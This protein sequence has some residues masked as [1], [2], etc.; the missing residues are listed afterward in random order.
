MPRHAPRWTRLSGPKLV[1][2][3]DIWVSRFRRCLHRGGCRVGLSAFGRVGRIHPDSGSNLSVPRRR[4]SR[5]VTDIDHTIPYP[6]GLTH[7][8]NLKCLCR[9]QRRIVRPFEPQAHS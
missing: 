4:S 6:L 7:A 9:K 2:R 8:S 1:E 5:R 3:I